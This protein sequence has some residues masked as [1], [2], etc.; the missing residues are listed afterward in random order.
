[1]FY[2]VTGFQFVLQPLLSCHCYLMTKIKKNVTCSNI[3]STILYFPDL[4]CASPL[5]GQPAHLSLAWTWRKPSAVR[6]SG[7]NRFHPDRRCERCC[8]EPVQNLPYKL[9]IQ[10]LEIKV[11]HRSDDKTKN[12]NDLDRKKN[13]TWI[14]WYLPFKG[15]SH[16]IEMSCWWCKWIVQYLETNLW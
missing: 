12:L 14:H 16:E 11:H 5:W 6:W 15:L 7:Q 8:P 9:Q 2:N 10:R 1:M 13:P 4:L 3:L